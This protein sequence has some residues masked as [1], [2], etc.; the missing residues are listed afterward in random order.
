MGEKI[1]LFSPPSRSEFAKRV[2]I[3][4]RAVNRNVGLL[5]RGM[6]AGEEWSFH[7][8][9]FSRCA[10]FYSVLTGVL[11]IHRRP[12]PLPL[13]FFI[14]MLGK[15]RVSATG[16]RTDV[17]S[18][19]RKSGWVRCSHSNSNPTWYYFEVVIDTVGHKSPDSSIHK[20]YMEA[21]GSWLLWPTVQ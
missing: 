2:R 10:P 11:A 20:K 17:I 7:F 12:T 21:H 19:S 3:T 9:G 14:I 1:A 4:G 8:L 13:P 18:C 6:G 5:R 15:N 16:A